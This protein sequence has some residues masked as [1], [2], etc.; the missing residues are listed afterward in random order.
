MRFVTPE[1]AERGFT[2]V[3]IAIAGLLSSILLALLVG[4]LTV[5]YRTS[6]FTQGQSFT[7]DDART[8]LQQVGR[9]I[10]NAS[11]IDWC[12]SGG[13]CLELLTWSPTSDLRLIRYTV[14]VPVLEKAEFDDDTSTWGDPR[15]VLGRLAN[16]A[17]QPVFTCDVQT[18]LLRINVDFVIQP[19]PNYA[20]TYHLHTSVR[21]RNFPS[22]AVCP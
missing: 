6:H 7:L 2:L 17:G 13:T 3:E 21:P 4:L 5:T 9:D 16:P 18:A 15:P 10:Q 1:R 12:A 20:A 19:T 22:S 8:S 11:Y 14:D